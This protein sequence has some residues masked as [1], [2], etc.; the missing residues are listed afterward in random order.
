MNE[1]FWE[2]LKSVKGKDLLHIALFFLALLPAAIYRHKR[3]HL[4][5]ICEKGAEA[6]DNGYWFFRYLRREQPR[7]DAVYAIDPSAADYEKVAVLGP[8]VKFGS[9]RHWIYYLA[10]QVNVSSQKDGKPNAAVCY[11]FEVLIPLIK[12]RS[13]FLQHGVTKDDLPF[14]HREKTNFDIFCCGALPEYEYVRE[15]FGYE[16]GVVQYT[17]LCRFDA[18]H[19]LSADENLVLIMPTW[20]MELQRAEDLDAFLHSDYYASWRDLLTDD[21]FRAL[22]RQHGKK[23]VFCMHRNME[24]F[25]QF[26]TYLSCDEIRVLRW[27]EAN[28]DQLIHRASALITDYSSVAMDFAY[29]K[30][31][32]FYYQFDYKEFREKHLPEGYFDY[33]KDGFGPV[34]ATARE[35]TDAL[36]RLFADPDGAEAAYARRVDGFYPL[37]DTKNCERT[38]KAVQECIS[39]EKL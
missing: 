6:K 31:P 19:G 34:V 16:S 35:L 33:V 26:F 17:G 20:R 28:I 22:L 5:L 12:T 7:V 21:N 13:V 37:H 23:A 2:K 32:L 27:Q 10:A 3:K 15:H 36:E 8:T 30:R 1:S 25:E 29:M 9:F 18:L 11:L 39:R 4:W 24:V 38:Y 14:L